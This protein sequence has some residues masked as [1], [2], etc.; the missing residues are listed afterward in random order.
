MQA[1]IRK[2]AGIAEGCLS[3]AQ[4]LAVTWR[5]AALQAAAAAPAGLAQSAVG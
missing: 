3:L 2:D 1:N 5:E 4:D